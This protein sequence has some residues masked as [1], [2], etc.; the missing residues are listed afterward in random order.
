MVGDDGFRR[1]G[2]CRRW[3]RA[4]LN[5]VIGDECEPDSRGRPKGGAFW[6][7]CES[8]FLCSSVFL[9]P[10]GSCPV[11]RGCCCRYG[12]GFAGVVALSLASFSSFPVPPPS[13]PGRAPPKKF[14]R[15]PLWWGSGDDYL[16]LARRGSD[17]SPLFIGQPNGG[18]AKTWMVMRC[19]IVG[20]PP[21]QES[22]I[23][24]ILGDA[25]QEAF[26]LPN[27]CKDCPACADVGRRCVRG[28]MRRWVRLQ[29]QQTGR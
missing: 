3:M 6:C 29:P 17:L 1:I 22:W 23:P 16:A 2:S 11:N 10:R 13:V 18:Y 26:G 7:F 27:G 15:N 4:G 12:D 5:H 19:R 21:F 9:W 20:I 8:R 24:M 14:L 28:D 25:A